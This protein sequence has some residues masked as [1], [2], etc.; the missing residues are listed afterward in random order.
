MRH[1]KKGGSRAC[2]GIELT[3]LIN[4]AVLFLTYVGV[5]YEG[6]SLQYRL[7][8]PESQWQS[9]GQTAYLTGKRPR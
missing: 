1:L 9:R 6:V 8:T 3:L 4:T 7:F 2:A 5:W